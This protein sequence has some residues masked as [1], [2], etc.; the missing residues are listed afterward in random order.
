M[1][2]VS[3]VVSTLQINSLHMCLPRGKY[4]HCQNGKVVSIKYLVD[5]KMSFIRGKQIK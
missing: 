5:K 2:K 1:E 4:I 3:V